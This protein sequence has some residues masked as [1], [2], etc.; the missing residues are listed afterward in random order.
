MVEASWPA[1]SNWKDRLP[2][3]ATGPGGLQSR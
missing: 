2:K 1:L 3:R